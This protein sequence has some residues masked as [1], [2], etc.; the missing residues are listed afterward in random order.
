V[1]GNFYTKAAILRL[2][3][4]IGKAS[5]WLVLHSANHGFLCWEF[6]RQVFIFT[7][8]WPNV[9][10]YFTGNTPDT[11]RELRDFVLPKKF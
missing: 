7:D 9:A 8:K 10:S 4:A 3:I 5:S 6:N 1:K 2:S 11:G